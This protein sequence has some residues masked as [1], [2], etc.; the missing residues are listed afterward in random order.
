MNILLL[1]AD[2]HRYDCLGACGNGQVRTP[3]IDRLARDAVR[4]DNSF[5]AYPVCTPSRYSLLSGLYVH[6]HAGWTNHCTLRPEIET[7]P[8]IM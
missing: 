8:R 4:Y 3:N 1:H 7:F 2:Q 6:Q 5:C